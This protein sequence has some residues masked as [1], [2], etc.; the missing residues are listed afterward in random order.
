[1]YHHYLVQWMPSLMILTFVSI[2]YAFEM[3]L[4]N[5]KTIATVIGLIYCVL[6]IIKMFV[7]VEQ[8][9]PDNRTI[10]EYRTP[11]QAFMHARKCAKVIGPWIYKFPYYR[12]PRTVWDQM[13]MV[14][15]VQ[16]YVK[17]GDPVFVWG[18]APE[19]YLLFNRPPASRFVYT[20]FV[21]GNFSAMANL[22]DPAD[23]SLRK[24]KDRIEKLLI[25]DL[26]ASRP[27]FIVAV[28]KEP[29][30]YTKFFFDYLSENYKR[31]DADMPLDMYIR[32]DNG[33]AIN[34][35]IK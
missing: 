11:V 13:N 6:F 25:D 23:S 7:P 30:K 26:Q 27:K 15:M 31:I 22:Y 1:M 14:K 32:K 3:F 29:N 17:P 24:Y 19:I 28:D 8:N 12:K 33:P 18:F 10:N 2:T 16:S 20:L 9:N 21:T 4:K 5:R 35:R 34:N